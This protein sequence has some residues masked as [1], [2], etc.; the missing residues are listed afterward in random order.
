MV[1]HP[2]RSE[3]RQTH[4]RA[5][6]NDLT[7]SLVTVRDPSSRAAEA[8][9]TL[10][11]NLLH[12]FVDAPPKVILITSPGAGEGKSITSANLAVVLAQAD[13]NILAIDCDFR[14]PNLH[15]YFGLRNMWGIVEVLGG[16][17]SLQDVWEEPVERLKVVPTGSVPPTPAELLD[18]WHFTEFL[19]GV[20]E[21]FDYVLL[22]TLPVGRVSDPLILATKSDGV[23]LVLD[24]QN[25]RKVSVRQTVRSLEAVGANVIG[26]VVN[27][28]QGAKDDYYYYYG[29][30]H[31]QRSR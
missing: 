6:T 26:T 16:D 3:V 29:Y 10:R 28:V 9:R 5:K 1:W 31:K 30:T 13:K 4:K 21:E 24:A 11:T 14:K 18:S 25:T 17:C 2:R 12:G 22:D 27:N 15:K 8:Y 7:E 23:L 20:R 19:A